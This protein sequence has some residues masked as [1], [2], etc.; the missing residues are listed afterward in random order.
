MNIS[1]FEIFLILAIV[2]FLFLLRPGK[3]AVVIDII[4]YPIKSC[5]GIHLERAEIEDLG[6]KNDR[7]WGIFLG[8]KVIS[9]IEEPKMLK[10]QPSFKYT[11]TGIHSHLVLSYPGFADYYL[12]LSVKPSEDS[13]F[14]L[15]E[16]EGKYSDE[17]DS[18]AEWLLGVFGKPYRLGQLSKPRDLSKLSCFKEQN[19]KNQGLSFA[20][21]GQILITTFESFEDVKVNVPL[22]IRNK[23]NIQCFRPNIVIKHTNNYEEDKWGNFSIG[24]CEFEGLKK[25]DR[26]RMTTLDSES[27]EF[28]PSCE[29]LNTLRKMHGDGIK[30][31][32]GLLAMRT[33][34]GL[35]RVGD[36][37]KVSSR[38][39]RK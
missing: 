15:E 24:E 25:C 26:C 14:N 19:I 32:F 27:F 34:N 5:A 11:S 10:L 22:Q 30:G 35:V 38:V 37:V 23:L 3:K 18:V 4:C 2:L 12:S 29:P 1:F 13:S 16:V 39:D 6:I 31:Y 8:K 20:S 36:K 21:E 28:D 7:K 17:G 33:K 9:Q